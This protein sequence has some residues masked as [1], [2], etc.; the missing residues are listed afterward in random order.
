MGKNVFGDWD[1]AS[2]ALNT[3][4]KQAKPVMHLVLRRL[5][6]FSVKEIK[7]GIRSQAP[8]NERFKPLA[9]ATIARRRAEGFKGTKALIRY[10]QLLRSIRL[11]ST[12]RGS[13]FVGIWRKR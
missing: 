8:N 13:F 12:G 9:K 3:I 11:T 5:A 4:Y 10:G 2:T 1:K 6:M 7:L